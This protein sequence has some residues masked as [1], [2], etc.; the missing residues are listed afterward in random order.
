V[1]GAAAE[2][3]IVTFYSYKG[4]TGRSMMLANVAWILASNGRRVLTIDW[5][6]EAPG[7]HRYFHP[8]L[9]DKT[10]ASSEGLMDFVVDYAAETMTPAEE[11]SLPDDWYVPHADIS[12]YAE[13][14][15][16]PLFAKPGTIDFVPAGRQGDSYASTV[17]LF[18]WQNFYDKLGGGAF[19]EAAKQ[20]MRSAYDYI[21]IDSRTGVS[22]TSGICT[23]QMPETVVLCFTLNIQSIDGAAAVAESIVRQQRLTGRDI[24]I[25]PVPT[26]VDRSEKEKVELSRLE[27]HRKFEPFLSHLSPQERADYWFAVEVPYEPW[28]SFE[29]VLVTFGDSSRHQSSM[30]AVMETI[31]SHITRGAVTRLQ[32]VTDAERKTVLAQYLRRGKPQEEEVVRVDAATRG[33]RAMERLSTAQQE[34][35]IA[36]I[37]R[38]ASFNA[39]GTVTPRRADRRFLGD[40]PDRVLQALEYADVIAIS[41]QKDGSEIVQLPDQDVFRDWSRAKRALEEDRNFLEWRQDLGEAV[42]AYQRSDDSADL[43]RGTALQNA[44]ARLAARPEGFNDAERAY[45]AASVGRIRVRRLSIAAAVLLPLLIAFAALSVIR[46]DR[47][48]LRM[49]LQEAPSLA[50]D[51]SP[52]ATKAVTAWVRSL[53]AASHQAEAAN[54]L[55]S[56]RITPARRAV[57]AAVY[58]EALA[59]RGLVPEALKAQQTADAALAQV[60]VPVERVRVLIDM[61]DAVGSRNREAALIMLLE[62]QGLVREM[63]HHGND[64][65]AVRAASRVSSPDR[66][67]SA[68]M[69]L[70]G[71]RARFALMTDLIDGMRNVDVAEDLADK[72]EETCQLAVDSIETIEPEV[73]A[74]LLLEL[75]SHLQPS[76]LSELPRRKAIEALGEMSRGPARARALDDAVAELVL[77]RNV[78][79]C[80]LVLDEVQN[81]PFDDGERFAAA[82]RVLST[83]ATASPRV[84]PTDRL[85]WKD[86]QA[87]V[88]RASPGARHVLQADLA[89]ARAGNEDPHVIVEALRKLPQDA[90]LTEPSPATSAS[91]RVIVSE[92]LQRLGAMEESR[93]V[94]QEALAKTGA[95][96]DLRVQ[97]ALY[98]QLAVG[99]ARAGSLAEAAAA[100]ALV[101]DDLTRSEYL[102]DLLEAICSTA[103]AADGSA[104]TET[105]VAIGLA[106]KTADPAVRDAALRD[107][108]AVLAESKHEAAIEAA[109]EIED[110]TVM[111]EALTDIAPSASLSQLVQL[112]TLLPEMADPGIRARTLVLLARNH[113]RFEDNASDVASLLESAGTAAD[114][115]SEAAVR[116][117]TR[118]EIASAYIL[119]GQL[120]PA[121]RAAA[122]CDDARD[123]LSAY[124][125]ILT[126]WAAPLP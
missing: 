64:E 71:Q 107:A 36:V 77:P 8:F 22:D 94:R 14:L 51:G 115:V 38:L 120:A 117:S 47:Y 2:G 30:L 27:A 56:P 110:D 63:V 109:A 3:H 122:S 93:A 67:S 61:A 91:R 124:A 35:G 9:R 28:Y 86:A 95:V 103:A 121:R 20:H 112:Q 7:L 100:A 59:A 125:A 90:L 46:T 32:Q 57:T 99:A 58:A 4:G 50:D 89:V 74:R 68:D 39:D 23:I 53:V 60:M 75:G 31:A 19:F 16:W 123:Q 29:E 73:R 1:T 6:L 34:Q 81:G 37:T 108:V 83:L 43:L 72:A 105:R 79:T 88:A 98:M 12:K 13:S 69:D 118:G 52:E 25:L 49:M 82:R 21:L 96:T 10:L 40:V 33:E 114:Q 66:A 80:A 42:S 78:T 84:A 76:P 11:G 102:D 113:H 54:L 106:R 104:L 24:R 55:A 15:R 85:F 41:R 65:T 119:L 116:S 111:L 26:R 126:H 5:D 17:N 62:A 18:N 44:R 87:I 70:S 101:R 92:A 48:Q 97:S 45:I